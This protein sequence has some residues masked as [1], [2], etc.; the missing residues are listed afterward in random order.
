LVTG[1][2]RI[3]LHLHSR[4]SPDSVT[5]LTDL[6][7][8][9]RQQGLD[10]IALTDHNTA[11]G[12]LGLKRLEPELVIVGEEVRTTEGDIIGLFITESI[13]PGQAAEAVCDRIHE[14]GGLAY[15]CHPLDRR[16]AHFQPDRLVEL[17]P[18]LDVIETHNPWAEPAANRAAADLCRE[19]G[20]VPATGSD[21]HS[22]RELGLSW[23]EIEPYGDPGD[24]LEKLREARHVVTD[25]SGKGRR[26]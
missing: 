5:S 17:A 6:V 26:G 2:L 20:K 24:F 7:A 11:E 22:T 12:A 8:R 19:L 16:R 15:A 10:R 13:A 3:D 21:A 18:H 1:R 9:C 14:M 4:F 25:R 23:M